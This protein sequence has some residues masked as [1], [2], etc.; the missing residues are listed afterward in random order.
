MKTAPIESKLKKMIAKSKKISY[1]E[2]LNWCDEDSK[3][4]YDNKSGVKI[5]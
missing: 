5:L 1:E 3:L 2:F 4:F